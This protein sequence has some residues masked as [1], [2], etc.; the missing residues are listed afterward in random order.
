[1]ENLPKMLIGRVAASEP[2]H[3]RWRTM[4]FQ[5]NEEIAILCHENGFCHFRG[6][7]N[8][9]IFFIAKTEVTNRYD[10]NAK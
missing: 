4:A 8:V 5:Q 2:Y 10:L 1:L 7:E 3:L 6:L 9:S